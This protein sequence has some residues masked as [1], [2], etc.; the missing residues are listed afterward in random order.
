M[1]SLIGISLCMVCSG[2]LVARSPQ[3]ARV[4][5]LAVSLVNCKYNSTDHSDFVFLP[6]SLCCGNL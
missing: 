5:L 4:L 2:A 6:I 1:T 3:L